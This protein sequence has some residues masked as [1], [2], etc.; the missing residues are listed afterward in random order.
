MK[1]QI[2]NSTL[3]MSFNR[4]SLLM[5]ILKIRLSSHIRNYSRDI[6]DFVKKLLNFSLEKITLINFGDFGLLS[7][8]I[9]KSKIKLKK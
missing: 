6:K 2:C 5:L 7:I 1:F 8:G 3:K 9:I 4:V